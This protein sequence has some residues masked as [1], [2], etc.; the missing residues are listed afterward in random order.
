MIVPPDSNY[1]YSVLAEVGKLRFQE[2]RQVD[3]IQI[4]LLTQH[5]IEI[6]ISEI[7]VLINN[8]ILYLTV[9]HEKSS[10]LIR[11]YIE[12]QGGYIL[13]LDATCEGDS[14]KLVSSIDPI[15]GFVL[16]SAK[17]NPSSP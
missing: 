10:E 4:I 12:K 3:E 5:G 16:Y 9:V 7:E 17:L 14:P 15:S 8:F 13:H 1:A 6:S 11:Q 2:K